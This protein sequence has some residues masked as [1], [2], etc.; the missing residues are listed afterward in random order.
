MSTRNA[1]GEDGTDAKILRRAW[2]AMS[3]VVTS[4]FG[5]LVEQE[6]FPRLWRSADIVNILKGKDKKRDDPKSFRPGS[7][8]P[9]LGKALE[10][11]VCTRLSDEIDDSLAVSQHGFRKGRSTISAIDEV[12]AWVSNRPEKYVLGVFLDISGAFDNVEWKPLIED[13]QNAFPFYLLSVGP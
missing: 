9:I 2:P 8:L 6:Y 5:D 3:Q 4:L 12:K 13:D 11:L 1:P 7:L 10:H